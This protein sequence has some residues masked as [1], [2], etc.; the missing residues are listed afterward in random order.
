[1]EPLFVIISF[2]AAEVWQGETNTQPQIN[3]NQPTNQASKQVT[4]QPACH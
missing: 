4:N 3:T 1:M 2:S